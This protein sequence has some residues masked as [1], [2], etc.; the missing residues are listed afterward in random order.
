MKIEEMINVVITIE[1]YN[2]RLCNPRIKN[3]GRYE[4]NKYRYRCKVCNPKYYL[5][6]FNWF[7]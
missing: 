5:V 1:K 2:C 7:N 3:Y 4:H 6:L